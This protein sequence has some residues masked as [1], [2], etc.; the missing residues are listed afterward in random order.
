VAESRIYLASTA[1]IIAVNGQNVATPLGLVSNVRLE[2]RFTIEGVPEWGS[3]QF[4]DLLIHGYEATFSWARAYSAGIDMVGQGLIPT[5]GEIANFA[6]IFLRIIDQRSQRQ[7]AMIHRGLA[8]TYSIGADARA[9]L[10]QDVS[11]RAISLL[12]ENELN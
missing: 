4:A 9:K 11:G 2:K 7:I 6:P 3:F 8:E 5:D 10:Q 12:F 1:S